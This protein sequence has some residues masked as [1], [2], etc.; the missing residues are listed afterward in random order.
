MGSWIRLMLSTGRRR[1]AWSELTRSQG[2]C[3]GRAVTLATI[4]VVC[5]R[6]AWGSC[7]RPRHSVWR[8]KNSKSMA[9]A[10]SVVS[11]SRGFYHWYYR[12]MDNDQFAKARTHAT[13]YRYTLNASAISYQH[14]GNASLLDILL[15][16][17]HASLRRGCLGWDA[18]CTTTHSR[19]PGGTS[20]TPGK[21]LRYALSLI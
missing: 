16:S 5:R 10:R 17:R 20:S 21:T 8:S 7:G 18:A 3:A 14:S 2:R 12:F 19:E 13:T 4:S 15:R 6:C 9:R 11:V 1:E